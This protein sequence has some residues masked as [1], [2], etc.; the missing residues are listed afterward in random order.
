[1]LDRESEI[2]G[3]IVRWSTDGD[4]FII[5]DHNQFEDVSTFAVFVLF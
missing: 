2:D 4:S 3:T 1:M 5:I